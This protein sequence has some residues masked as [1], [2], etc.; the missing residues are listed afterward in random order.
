M[1]DEEIA[2]DPDR[3]LPERIAA[4]AR[5]WASIQSSNAALDVLKEH[6]RKEA[7]KT[8]KTP[9]TVTIEGE[10]LSRALV[11][12]PPPTLSLKKGAD[13]STHRSDFGRSFALIFAPVPGAWKLKTNAEAILLRLPKPLQT[14]A[15]R[16]IEES[17][18][19]PRVYFESAGEGVETL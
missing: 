2:T 5:L 7:L 18:P 6:L 8:Q 15:F 16:L 19:K 12:V 4:G 10:G 14:L 17:E 11:V 1:R 9:G 3:P 13:P